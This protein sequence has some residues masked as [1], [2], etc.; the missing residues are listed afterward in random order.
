MKKTDIK[1]SDDQEMFSILFWAALEKLDSHGDENV[2]PVLNKIIEK[3]FTNRK[4]AEI[5]S[6]DPFM[7]RYRK[8]CAEIKDKFIDPETRCL[9]IQGEEI[10]HKLELNKNSFETYKSYRESERHGG[11]RPE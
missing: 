1:L 2:R 10:L 6:K 4:D 7:E 5:T 8:I 9:S 3:W 11:F